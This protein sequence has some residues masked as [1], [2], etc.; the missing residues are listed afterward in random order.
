MPIASPT[1][2]NWSSDPRDRVIENPSWNDIE[3]AIRALDNADRND[4][5]LTPIHAS[6]DTFIGVGGGAGRYIVHESEGG[7][8]FPTLSN[9]DSTDERL[10]PL[11][12]GGQLGEYPARWIVDLQR[13][14]AAAREFYE[15]RTFDCGWR[16]KT[17]RLRF[18]TASA[19]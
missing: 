14:L 3:T 16:G 10:E 12:V 8:R 19:A 15:A 11:C 18:H 5:Y 6:P 2:C 4:L 7:K 9:P 1:I 17:F 13:A